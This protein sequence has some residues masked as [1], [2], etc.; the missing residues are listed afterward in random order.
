MA[1]LKDV[2]RL[3][4]V[5]TAT[6]SRAINSPDVVD[7]TTLQKIHLAMKK[8]NYRPNLLAS[9]LRSKSSKQIALIVPDA[10]HYSN[11]SM[12]HHTSCLLQDLGYTLILGTH[13][14]KFE[15]ESELLNNFFSRNIDGII[16][17]MIFNETLAVQSLL[18]HQ[19]R[20]VPIVIVG[21]R[22][23]VDAFSNVAIDNYQAGVMA[24]E[25]LGRIGHRHVA[26]VT[27]PRITQWARDRL[28]GFQKGLEKYDAK[29][30]WVFSQESDSDFD[31]GLL[32]AK[33]FYA[34]FTGKTFPTAIWSQNDIMASA[35]L[36]QLGLYGLRVPE[37]IS[38]LGMDDIEL[39]T[40]IT[41]ALSTIHQPFS[42][43]AQEAIKILMEDA[44]SKQTLPPRRVILEPSLIVRESTL[45]LDQRA[46][47]KYPIP[48]AAETEPK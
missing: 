27:G 39:A 17:Y 19:E 20:H 7:P 8:L 37:D 28:D 26:T 12:I 2:A 4:E 31:T 13:H 33:E 48:S 6:V 38:L 40:I 16:L 42:K 3:A 25:Y 43:I 10:E 18:E 45:A 35:I 23:N 29:I 11:A 41:P 21:R 36:K 34:R 24:G 30:E 22:I 1:S 5:S 15:I 44:R 46:A 32:A 14:N 47:A 9:G